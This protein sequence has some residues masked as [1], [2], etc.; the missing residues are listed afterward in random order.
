MGGGSSKLDFKDDGTKYNQFQKESTFTD[1]YYTTDLD[2]SKYTKEQKL[3]A[4]RIEKEIAK[5]KKS[6]FRNDHEDDDEEM[7][8]KP[9]VVTQNYDQF[10]EQNAVVDIADLE[11]KQLSGK[12]INTTQ[13][14]NAPGDL[15]SKDLMKKESQKSINDFEIGDMSSDTKPP[16]QDSESNNGDK[17]KMKMSS[18]SFTPKASKPTSDSTKSIDEFEIS[19]GKAPEKKT[20]APKPKK[21]S[22]LTL[23]S[24]TKSFVPTK[25]APTSTPST[26][27]QSTAPTFHPKQPSALSQTVTPSYTPTQPPPK[28]YYPRNE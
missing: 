10:I 3:K 26:L 28:P 25:K 4:A 15:S 6:N 9:A 27:S 20:E 8:N 1:S 21:T 16:V 18:R 19:E 5:G 24:N 11:R 13:D 12:L 23:R 22:K 7:D 14:S 2:E 17:P